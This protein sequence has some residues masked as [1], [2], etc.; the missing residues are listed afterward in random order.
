M[1]TKERSPSGSGAELFFFCVLQIGRNEMSIQ[2]IGEKSKSSASLRNKAGKLA[3]VSI[4]VTG[5]DAALLPSLQ[6]AIWIYSVQC[7]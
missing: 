6:A 7:T 2:R 3:L 5:K 1:E 4:S